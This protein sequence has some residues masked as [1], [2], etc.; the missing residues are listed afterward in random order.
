LLP[1]LY[2]YYYGGYGGYGLGSAV[3]GGSYVPSPGRSYSTGTTRG[4]FGGFFSESS[5]RGAGE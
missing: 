4:G 2:H 3:R 5:G 1:V